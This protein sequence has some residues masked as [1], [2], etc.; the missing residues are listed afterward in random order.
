MAAQTFLRCLFDDAL[1]A[2]HLLHIFTIER[3]GADGKDF[4]RSYWLSDYAE[5]RKIVSE[6]PKADIYFGTGLSPKDCGPRNRC[7]ADEIIAIPALWLDLDYK[8]DTHSKDNLPPT[9]RD[10]LELIQQSLPPHLQPT[11]TVHTGHGYQFYWLFKELWTFDTPQEREKAAALIKSWQHTIKYHAASRGWDVDSTFDLARVFRLPGS[12]NLKSRPVSVT[13]ENDTRERYNPEDFENV[14]VEVDEASQSEISGLLSKDK[15]PL[16]IVVAPHVNPPAEKFQAL[17]AFSK[18]FVEL[19]DL[20]TGN[21][22]GDTSLSSH[23]LGLANICIQYDWTPQEVADLIITF[24][25][26]KGKSERDRL[27][28]LRVDYL[29]RTILLAIQGRERLEANEALEDAAFQLTR[30]GDD[31]G[32]VSAPDVSSIKANLQKVLGVRIHRIWKYSGDDPKFEIE[33]EDGQ[34]VMIGSVQNLIHQGNLRNILAAHCG[35]LLNRFKQEVWDQYAT[36]LLRSCDEVKTSEETSTRKLLRSY[37]DQYIGSAHF[38]TDWRNSFVDQQPFRKE[39][40][41]FIYGGTFRLWLKLSAEPMSAKEMGVA[42]ASLGVR[43]KQQTFAF[44]DSEGNKQ[45]TTR[46]V[47][48]VTKLISTKTS[49]GTPR[50]TKVVSLEQGKKSQPK[51]SEKDYDKPVVGPFAETSE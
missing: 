27:K 21:K 17:R 28:G 16:E 19:F 18:R 30:H 38:A 5:I 44:E 14:L 49:K 33:L 8:H 6:N 9:K 22:E 2:D 24:R 47:Y 43:S 15:N 31:P 20:K 50:S 45:R 7:P 23:D 35:V 4:K 29:N 40:R 13:I 26:E 10:A 46:S 48:D 11:L 32:T 34:K 36:L 41:T 39:G 42:F 51:T 12:L 25:R 1:D 3:G 37:V